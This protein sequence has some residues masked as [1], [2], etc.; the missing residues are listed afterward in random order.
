MIHNKIEISDKF[1]G[2]RLEGWYHPAEHLGQWDQD[3]WKSESRTWKIGT[4]MLSNRIFWDKQ[5][6]SEWRG[7]GWGGAGSDGKI[8]LS[9]TRW[10]GIRISALFL[11]WSLK[12]AISIFIAWVS[13]TC[14]LLVLH[15]SEFLLFVHRCH[16]FRGFFHSNQEIIWPGNTNHWNIILE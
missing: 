7:E 10:W 1:S 11:V 12:A 14:Q 6:K 4:L 8:V 2:C 5:H 3:Y 13:R 16:F 15:L 9:Q